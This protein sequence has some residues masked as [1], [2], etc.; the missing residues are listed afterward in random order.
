MLLALGLNVVVGWAGLLDL[1]YI[2]FF[3]FGAYVYAF[4]APKFG[5]HLPTPVA[6]P[7]VIVFE[8]ALGLLLGLALVAALGRLPRDRDAV[9]PADLP[10]AGDERERTTTSRPPTSPAGANG[11]LGV[12]PF[13]F[14]GRPRRAARR[15]FPSPTTSS[16]SVSS[17]WSFVALRFLNHSRTG[18]AWRASGRTRSPPR[19]WRFRQPAE[20]PGLHVRRRDGG[21]DRLALR[22]RSARASSRRTSRSPLLITIYAMVI[23]GGSGSIG[24]V[25]LG[26][27]TMESRSGLSRT[28]TGRA[29][30]STCVLTGRRRD[31]GLRLYVPLGSSVVASRLR[32]RRCTVVAAVAAVVGDGAADAGGRGGLVD[33]G[34]APVAAGHWVG[35]RRVRRAGPRRARADAVHGWARDRARRPDVYLGAFVWENLLISEPERHAVPPPRRTAVV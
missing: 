32:L 11:I 29:S 13:S 35:Q 9:L 25:V 12:D 23:L 19:R 27:V 14:L 21:A 16:R 34:S 6:V 3:G 28:P 22:P 24:G 18:R 30:S 4:F 10:R 2:A 17:S 20:A 33:T 26:A 7:V 15:D 5:I 8:R 1:G 31:R